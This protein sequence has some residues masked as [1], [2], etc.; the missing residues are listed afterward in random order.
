MLK[1]L[2]T[3]VTGGASGLGRGTVE[4]FVREGAKVTL[5]DLPTSKGNEVASSFKGDTCIFVPGDVTK[6]ADVM[7][8][9]NATKEKFGKLDVACNCAGVGVAFKTYNF[10]KDK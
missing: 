9:L 5:I 6:E 2:V 7:A 1:G 4:R 3:L 10:N 8:A